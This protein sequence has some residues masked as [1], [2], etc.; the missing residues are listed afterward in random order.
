MSDSYYSCVTLATIPSYAGPFLAP[1]LISLINDFDVH[2]MLQGAALIVL[3]VTEKDVN[4]TLPSCL[5][6][7]N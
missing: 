4:L 1:K 6:L 3:Y 5:R 7:K 2:F